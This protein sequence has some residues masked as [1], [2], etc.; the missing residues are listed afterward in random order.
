MVEV[1]DDKNELTWSGISVINPIIFYQAG[2]TSKNFNIW[3]TVLPSYIKEGTITGQKS[4]D[5]WIDVG[6]LERLKLANSVYNENK[7]E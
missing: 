6:T 7:D 2:F 1:K 4:S 5:L 3:D